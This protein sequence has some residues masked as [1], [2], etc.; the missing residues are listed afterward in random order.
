MKLMSI[1]E[2]RAASGSAWKNLSEDGEW[3]LT[4]NGRPVAI[5]VPVQ[6][7][8]LDEEITA[9]RQSSALRAVQRMQTHAMTA[10]LNRL[11]PDEIDQEIAAVRKAR[12]QPK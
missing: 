3:V 9:I 8:T 10:K 2:L 4:N 7:D 1:R 6:G 5:L 12:K 11:T